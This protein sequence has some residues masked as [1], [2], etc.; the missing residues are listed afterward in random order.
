M[1]TNA[2]GHNTSSALDNMYIQN[3]F[4][5]NKDNFFFVFRFFRKLARCLM[6]K[7][8]VSLNPRDF[9]FSPTDDATKKKM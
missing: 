4:H 1:S 5:E 7:K 8:N 3:N 2:N 9:H 6:G